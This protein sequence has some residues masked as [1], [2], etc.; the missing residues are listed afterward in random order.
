MPWLPSALAAAAILCAAA[1]AAA[2][3]WRID[4]D[5]SVIRFEYLEDGEAKSGVFERFSGR[6]VF[7]RDRPDRATLILEIRTDSVELEDGF[8]TSFVQGDVWFDT[9]RHPEARYELRRLE[10]QSG[11]VYLATGV[12]TI[13]G[14]SRE[15]R[16][17]LNIE[18]EQGR[19]RAV[20]RLA[21]N[22]FDFEVG[23]NGL[24]VDIGDDI[25]VEFD[26][27]ATGR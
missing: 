15:F 13:K 21:F 25:A 10:P 9:E 18:I 24:F 14:I 19:A 23:D 2:E 17:P 11:D 12:L 4:P 7:D 1:P 26:L 8:R 5:E 6:G 3:I 22:R 20:G 27:V 16:I